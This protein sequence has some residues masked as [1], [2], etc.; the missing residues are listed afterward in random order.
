DE[1]LEVL[2]QRVATLSVEVDA[3]VAGSALG[4][5]RRLLIERRAE[6]DRELARADERTR[7]EATRLLNGPEGASP[8]ARAQTLRDTERQRDDAL[9]ARAETA[10]RLRAAR[11]ARDRLPAGG[12]SPDDPQPQTA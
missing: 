1:P 2:E 5:R 8:E 7:A 6:L 9:A 10:E 3:A 11:A 4:E 12:T